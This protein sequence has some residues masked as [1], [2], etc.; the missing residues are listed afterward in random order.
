MSTE[1]MLEINPC[2]HCGRSDSSIQ[3]GISAA[4]WYFSL[5]QYPK[6]SGLPTNLQE[7]VDAFNKGKIIDEY[8]KQITPEEMIDIITN[9]SHEHKVDDLFLK[10][11]Q[12]KH[13][14]NNLVY[15]SNEIAP[16][17]DKTYCLCKCGYTKHPMFLT[18]DAYL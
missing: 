4:G 9:R 8:G 6:E 13:G 2:P 1:Y 10:R 18:K 11:N 12:C 14:I 16:E 17:D 7:W 15:P 3:I 5:N